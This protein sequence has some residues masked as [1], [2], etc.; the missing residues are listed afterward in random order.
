MAEALSALEALGEE[1]E[2]EEGEEEEGEEEGEVGEEEVGEEAGG[3]EPLT[4][5]YEA[6]GSSPYSQAMGGRLIREASEAQYDDAQ[7]DEQ[8]VY[9]GR[10]YED[11]YDDYEEDEGPP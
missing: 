6:E 7:Y 3:D 2:E 10:G 4:D 9:E 11:D 5:G 1:G 8:G